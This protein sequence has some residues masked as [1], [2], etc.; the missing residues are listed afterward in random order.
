M[1]IMKQTKKLQSLFKGALLL[2]SIMGGF[3]AFSPTTHAAS[4]EVDSTADTGA[5]GTL[6]WAINE[7]N[8]NA[9]SDQITFNI[10]GGGPHTITLSSALPSIT[11]QL[12]ID[13]LTQSGSACDGASTLPVVQLDLN[14]LVNAFTVS[15]G[16]VNTEVNGLAIFNAGANAYA[17]YVAGNNSKIRCNFFGT[18]DG[19]TVATSKVNSDWLRI[20]GDN[21]TVGGVATTDTN[22]FLATNTTNTI[23]VFGDDAT[24]EHNFSGVTVDG[25]GAI[26]VGNNVTVQDVV[27]GLTIRNNHFFAT[28]DGSNVSFTGFAS[29]SS[30]IVIDNN[31]FNVESTGNAE[32]GNS[33]D[34]ILFS[35]AYDSVIISNNTITASPSLISLSPG[36]FTDFIIEDNKLN[37]SQ[38]GAT[39]LSGGGNVF[40]NGAQ[41]VVLT[42][43]QLYGNEVIYVVNSSNTVITGNIIGQDDSLTTCFTD[44][45][46]PIVIE[47]T[48]TNTIIGGTTGAEANAICTDSSDNTANGITARIP[49][50]N[51][52]LAVL[53]NAISA[54]G[55]AIAYDTSPLTPPVLRS[56]NEIGGNTEVTVELNVPAG[57]YRVEFFNNTAADNGNG[58]AQISEF[59]GSDSF[60]SSGSGPEQQTLTVPST[61]HTFITATATKEDAS[62]DGFL[63]TSEVSTTSLQT[64]LELTTTGPAVI[65][66]GETDLELTQTITNTGPSAVTEINFNLT[67]NTCF[68]VSSVDTAGSASDPGAYVGSTWNGLLESG[69]SLILTFTGDTSACDDNDQVIFTNSITGRSYNSDALVDTDASNEDPSHTVAIDPIVI[70][71]SLTS[72][73]ENPEDYQP[74]GTVNFTLTVHNNGPQPFDLTRMNGAEPFNPFTDSVMEMLP[75]DLTFGSVVSPNAACDFLAPAGAVGDLFANHL[76][77]NIYRCYYTGGAATLNNGQ[78][79]DIEFTAT[80][81]N[82]SELKYPNFAGVMAPAEDTNFTVYENCLNQGAAPGD[83]DFLD[84][85]IVNPINNISWAGAPTDV[86]VTSAIVQPANFTLGSTVGQTITVTN[87]GPGNINL[88]DYATNTE[89]FSVLYDASLF[90]YASTDPAYNCSSAPSSVIGEAASDHP[91]FMLLSCLSALDSQ[92]LEAGESQQV[93]IYYQV[94]G[95]VAGTIPF[96][97]LHASTAADPDSTALFTAIFTATEDIF[98]T[99][100]GNNNF[101]KLAYDTNT[102]G[103]SS[104][105]D[106]ST[107]ANPGLLSSTGQDQALMLGVAFGMLLLAVVG[108]GARKRLKTSSHHRLKL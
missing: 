49:N 27:D 66:E 51:A 67:S 94:I 101:F 99:Y 65:L 10:A 43:N 33:G 104:G 92:V 105:G 100:S 83:P 79:F 30:D 77:Y 73:L 13:G 108:V 60:T 98:D 12:T 81:A 11:E 89:F 59:I 2:T 6:R 23:N 28:S 75:D 17:L 5:A 34:G 90:S 54:G 36:P 41:G 55:K 82:D 76:N 107:N 32:L 8:A 61:G 22:V 72:T 91:D 58:F 52:G 86:E 24:I 62:S 96:Y 69:Q 4:Y 71:L 106:S 102:A 18:E 48:A 19:L 44:Q 56:I 93:T 87:N 14:D 39:A 35:G 74:G 20:D 50:A 64:D 84:C 53:G 95:N 47:A 26:D 25:L 42:G 103:N 46:T 31:L 3:F 97:A 80:V 40:L 45:T 57:Q 63:T 37:V 70:D 15:A 78:S 38:D 21:V 29:G 16:A 9:G 7:A 85:L 68:S 1:G 88:A